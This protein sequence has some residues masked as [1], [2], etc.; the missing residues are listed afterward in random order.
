MIPVEGHSDLFR[1]EIT[2]AIINTDTSQ[3]NQ[4]ISMRNKKRSEK[5]E[6]DKMKS[7]S[8]EIK[9]LLTELVNPT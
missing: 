2:G 1:D 8:E 7:D 4:Y 6:V 5:E 9:S 3:Y